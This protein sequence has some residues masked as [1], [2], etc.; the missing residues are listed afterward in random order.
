MNIFVT[1]TFRT[2][3]EAAGIIQTPGSE[4]LLTY[5][6]SLAG[7]TLHRPITYIVKLNF[8]LRIFSIVFPSPLN[9]SLL[10]FTRRASHSEISGRQLD[11]RP[12]TSIGIVT[13]PSDDNAPESVC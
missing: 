9:V 1:L 5:A 7:H 4:L 11:I 12:K 10:P 8:S 3:L 13:A 2:S 6:A